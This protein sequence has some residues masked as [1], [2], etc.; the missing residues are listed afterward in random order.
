MQLLVATTN[1]GKIRELT[2]LLQGLTIEL[3]TLDR[4]TPRP[5]VPAEVMET[6]TGNAL[7][8][9]SHY[10]RFSGLLTLAD[11]SGLEV[12]ALGGRPGVRSAEYGG[13]GLS[14]AERNRL[15]LEEMRDVP[16]GR[17]GA[18]FVCVVALV[19]TDI[20]R[21]FV[22]SCEGEIATTP[23]GSDGFGYDP[24]FIDPA[25]RQSFASLPMEE[26]SKRSHRGQAF[27]GLLGCLRDL[28][29]M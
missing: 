17:R 6:F 13:T 1:E 25:T 10:H 27:S 28:S 8:K 2:A 16:A 24:I 21:T 7:L 18:R 19:G 15:L 22:G 5:P 20:N 11:D 26:K 23:T 29:R 14:S 9:A 4:L 12:D 3:V